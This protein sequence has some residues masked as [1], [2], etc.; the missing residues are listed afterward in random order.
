[1]PDATAYVAVMTTAGSIEEA[2]KIAAALVGAGKAA[3]VQMAAIESCYAWDGAVRTEPERLL[4]VKTRRSLYPEVESMIRA[5][6]S[7]ATPEI[8]CLPIVAGSAAYLDWIAS[9]TAAPGGA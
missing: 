1:M 2:R 6:H 9:V 5:F 8:V 7:Y 4:I 3:C